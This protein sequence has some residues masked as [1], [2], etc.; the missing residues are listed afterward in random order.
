L[1]DE[2]LGV[3]LCLGQ[4]DY[5]AVYV[6]AAAQLLSSSSINARRLCRFALMERVES[7]LFFIA[8]RGGAL[9]STGRTVALPE[10]KL[11]AAI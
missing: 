5:D 7:V 6:R 9:R 1:S 10:R 4:H 8:A 3:A 11:H 2:E